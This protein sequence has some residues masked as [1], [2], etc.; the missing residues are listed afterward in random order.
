MSPD[1]R[2][3]K[4]E[5]DRK[6]DRRRRARRVPSRGPRAPRRLIGHG[7]NV[8]QVTLSVMPLELD[9]IDSEAARLGMNRSE[10]LR[11]AAD[12]WIRSREQNEGRAP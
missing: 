7:S 5:I 9:R 11:N 2:L 4:R 3:R 8:V 1:A 10:F 12:H 6:S